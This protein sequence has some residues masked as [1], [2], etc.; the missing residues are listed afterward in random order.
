MTKQLQILLAVK[1]LVEAALPAAEVRGFDGDTSKPKKIDAGGCVVGHPGEPGEPEFTLSPLTYHYEHAIPLEIAAAGGVGGE[2]L[3]AMLVPIGAAVMA[4]TTLGGLCH[5]MACEAADRNDR[6][7]A[8]LAT[9]NWA[10]VNIV[11]EYSTE[12]P[13]G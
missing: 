2:A 4:D 12:N 5:F 10:V 7:V 6:T 8:G 9:S 1:A 13:L 3:D 11:C